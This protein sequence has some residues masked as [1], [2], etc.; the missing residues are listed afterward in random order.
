MSINPSHCS[1]LK[2]NLLRL[3]LFDKLGLISRV[4]LYGSSPQ[5][6][7]SCRQFYKVLCKYISPQKIHT[8]GS[9]S[10]HLATLLSR[11]FYRRL[12]RARLHQ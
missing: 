10:S 12:V 6:R 7:R 5:N 8:V 1:L 9:V 2:L 4:T 3:M 11:S